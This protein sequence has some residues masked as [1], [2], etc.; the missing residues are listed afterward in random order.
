MSDRVI[1]FD[2]SL[3]DGEQAPG[4]T[5]NLQ[6]K[7][8][9]AEQLE[10][11]GVDVIE[12]GFPA[13]SQ[14]D[15]ES[16]RAV[17][18]QVK[19][20][21]IAVLNRAL[22]ADIDT[23]WEA[24][25]DAADPRLH[26]FLATSPLHMQYKLNKTPD[27]VLEILERAVKYATKYTSN[28]EFSA[29]D[30]SRSDLK[31]LATV[32]DTAIKAGATTINI[33][34]TVGYAQPHE[35]AERIRYLLE[36]VPDSDKAVFSVHCH[37]DLGLGVANTMAALYAGARQA[38]VTLCGIGERAGNAALEE[39]VMALHTRKDYYNLDC[40]VKTNH[41]FHSCRFISM[42]IGQ[43][44]PANKS[45]VGANA[46]AH[47]SGIHQDGMLKHRG[48]YE[49]MTPESIGKTETELVLGKHSGRSAVNAKLEGLGYHLNEEQLSTVLEAIKRLGS[50]KA[51]VYDE[52]LEALVL[53]EVYRL[54]DDYRLENLSLSCGTTGVPPT[55]AVEMSVCGEIKRHAAFGVGPV[56]AVFNTIA[57]IA[58]RKPSISRYSVN[59]L[60]GGTAAQGE[61]TV[62]MEEDGCSSIGRGADPDIIIASAKAYINALNRLVK[63]EQQ[64]PKITNQ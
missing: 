53:E 61:V 47:E 30:A 3:R 52:D 20:C 29:E 18:A 40:Q 34:D 35:F 12:A 38:E 5:M 21:Q 7:T 60:T 10:M 22:Q 46:F 2:T 48:T 31:F 1:I 25:K 24:V 44:I 13:S 43:P 32:V 63:M 37:D 55:A 23:G 9:L 58:E 11:L 4:A 50:L 8:R 27:Q 14:S 49:I 15:F 28:I 42:L 16:V 54:P 51:E 17:A 59:A 41:I 6:E 19:D 39:V 36:N 62:I 26:I 56:D 33:P 57:H 45:I 64:G